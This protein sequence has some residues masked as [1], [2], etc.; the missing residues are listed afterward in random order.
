M[1]SNHPKKI[2]LQFTHQLGIWAVATLH[3][4]ENH[5]VGHMEPHCHVTEKKVL[6][7]VGTFGRERH[8]QADFKWVPGGF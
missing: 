6:D 8:A 1:L 5:G 2:L 3:K 7:A 4:L